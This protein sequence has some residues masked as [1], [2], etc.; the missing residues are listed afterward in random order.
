MEL[1]V[2]TQMVPTTA[3][4]WMAT[5]ATSVKL[6]GLNVIMVFCALYER[7]VVILGAPE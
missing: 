6:V 7:Y 3:R 5:P 2:T 4:A 1:H